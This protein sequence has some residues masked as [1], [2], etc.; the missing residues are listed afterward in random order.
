MKRAKSSR[1][2]VEE[3]FGRRVVERP[4]D[5]GLGDAVNGLLIKMISELDGGR[6]SPT[7]QRDAARLIQLLTEKK[8]GRPKQL[9]SSAKNAM[10]S[11]AVDWI[12]AKRA[13]Q[14]DENPLKSAL[15]DVRHLEK[16]ESGKLL[17]EETL[18]N[19]Y[20][21]GLIDRKRADVDFARQIDLEARRLEEEEGI[22]EGLEEALGASA[23]WDPEKWH[24]DRA[25]YDRGRRWLQK[26]AEKK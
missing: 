11:E 4:L 15:R 6:A 1:Q 3:F 13:A 12:A 5:Q 24:F 19:Y 9:R 14:R 20:Q 8:R 2:I 23:E 17:S 18:L 26:P 16:A 7:L 21:K 10:F 22:A 25:R